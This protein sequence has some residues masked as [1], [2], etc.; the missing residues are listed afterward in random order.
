[1][2]ILSKIDYYLL[3]HYFVALL[4]VIL[5]TGLTIVVIN[6]IEEL[7]DF[8]DHSVPIL[9]VLE[10]YL[11]FGGWVIKSFF[12]MFVLLA[13]LFSVTILARRS[14]IMAMNISGISL[15]RIALPLVLMT[16]IL[17]AGHFY[18]NE[19]IFPPANKKRLEIKEFTIEKKSKE[20]FARA[21]NIY[22]Q[23]QP[24]YFYTIGTFNITRL[25]GQDFKLYKTTNRELSQI[26]TARGILYHDS[27]WLAIDGT[28]R[29]FDSTARQSYVQFD[30][31]VITDIA[32]KPEDLARKMGKPEDMGLEE[33]ERYIDL[34]KRTGGPYLRES[35]DLKLK[36]AYPLASVIILFI[37]I[38]FA[39][40]AR[41]GGIAASVAA[42]A[43]IALIYFVLFRVTQSSGYNAKIPE[44]LA[45]W[46]VN[47]LFFIV[48]IILMLKASK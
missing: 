21:R 3:R 38:P 16:L 32:D 11:Y 41:R 34:M 46:G 47:V 14:E 29:Y 26:T 9:S 4:V 40:R 10:Y 22:R 8:I 42:G 17:A 39:A 28:A 43:V 23:I 12:P 20:H 13:T 5:A 7:R 44:D 25:S 31:L 2:T 24:G 30:T 27:K 15:Y 6:M 1:M 45:V 36:Y 18:Y 48:G 19:Y 33:L 35:I 37:S